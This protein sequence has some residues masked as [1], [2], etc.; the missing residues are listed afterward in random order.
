MEKTYL[1]FKK[2]CEFCSIEFTKKP[3]FGKRKWEKKRFCSKDCF[4]KSQIGIIRGPH[5]EQFKQMV[6]QQH[7][8]KINSIETRRKMAENKTGTQNPNWKG[9][10]S[11]EY[12]LQ[13]ASMECKIWR[14]SVFERDNYTCIWCKKK[15]GW[16]KEE[17]RQI[18]LNA[19]HIK[20]F[21]WFPDLRFD[22]NNGRTLCYDCHKK[23]DTYGSRSLKKPEFADTTKK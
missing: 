2:N 18:V 8:G 11:T 20:S 12:Q 15:G 22:I 19:D 17:K 7:K 13:R 16:S 6:S 9:G 5:T 10:I 3:N 21:L 23:T 14:V 1:E 4:G